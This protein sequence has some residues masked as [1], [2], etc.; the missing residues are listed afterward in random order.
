M[1][2]FLLNL[3]ALLF[4]W[5]R[6]A[7]KNALDEVYHVLGGA[8]VVAAFGYVVG[9]YPRLLTFGNRAAWV[10][11]AFGAAAMASIGWEW[12]EFALDRF[13]FILELP[14]TAQGDMGDTMHD[15]FFALVGAALAI[16]FFLRERRS[17]PA[18]PDLGVY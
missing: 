18:A 3:F 1:D 10:F 5:Y 7:E 11:A 17:S 14:Y 16:G 4:G 9:R 2:L 12:F 6:Y 8:W 15:F 13:V